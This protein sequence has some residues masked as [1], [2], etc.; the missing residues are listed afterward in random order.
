[1]RGR[2]VVVPGSD[3][4]VAALLPRLLPRGLVLMLSAFVRRRPAQDLR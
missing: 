1:M 4:K 2:R 3:N